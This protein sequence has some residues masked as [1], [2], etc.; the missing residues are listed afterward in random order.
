MKTFGMLLLVALSTS[1]ALTQQ[2]DQ[3]ISEPGGSMLGDTRSEVRA[4]LAS[5]GFMLTE[6]VKTDS[7]AMRPG[8][9]MKG[10][11]SEND[12]PAPLARK[13]GAS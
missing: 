10:T 8:Q 6:G 4:R 11:R 2:D 1:P 5:D 13:G 3:K 9:R 12:T 7:G